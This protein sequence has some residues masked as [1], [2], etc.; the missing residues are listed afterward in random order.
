[1]RKV[2]VCLLAIMPLFLLLNNVT[3]LAAFGDKQNDYLDKGKELFFQGRVMFFSGNNKLDDA[4]EV[5]EKSKDYFSKLEDRFENA[6]WRGKVEYVLGEIAEVK[7]DKRKAAQR[8]SESSASAENA[9]SYNDSSSSAL[10]LLANTYMRLM[11]Y[12]GTI[13]AMLHSSKTFKLLNKAKKLDKDNYSVYNSFAMC[14][15][16][17]PEFAGGSINKAIDSLE[18]ALKSEDQ[19]T[20][21]NSYMWLGIIYY[22]QRDLVNAS[23]NFSKALEIYP[24][25]PWAKD[26]MNQIKE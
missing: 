22:N 16:Y 4:V 23:A 18:K 6:Y 11:N 25:S 3:T 2:S 12:K 8:F 21:F 26:Y 14:Y 17:T 20:N 13:Y 9:I 1:M 7:N 5:L 15:F 10:C 24:N 19:F